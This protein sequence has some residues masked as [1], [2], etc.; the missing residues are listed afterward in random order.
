MDLLL[1][2]N[3]YQRLTILIAS[4][5]INLAAQYCQRLILLR[6]G[7]IQGMGPPRE[8]I[9]EALIQEVFDTPV[10]Q[11]PVEGSYLVIDKHVQKQ[12]GPVFRG[13]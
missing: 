1:E 6:A 10:L 2:L 4:P 12:I 5:D 13:P 3:Q 9:E 11:D 8:V 7:R